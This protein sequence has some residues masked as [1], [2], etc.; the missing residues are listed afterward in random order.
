[1]RAQS[2]NTVKHDKLRHHLEISV[3]WEVQL[4]N[5]NNL[6]GGFDCRKTDDALTAFT[7]GLFEVVEGVEGLV[8]ALADYAEVIG[9]R[10]V[11]HFC[12]VLTL[13]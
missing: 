4:L 3:R 11:L 6:T 2:L 9:L 13:V 8:V 12:D 10:N 7:E 1:M 5:D